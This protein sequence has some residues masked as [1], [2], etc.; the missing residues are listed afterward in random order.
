ME[1]GGE[2]EG[3]E[4]SEVEWREETFGGAGGV[5]ENDGGEQRRRE[6]PSVIGRHAIV[7]VSEQN[8]TVDKSTDPLYSYGPNLIQTPTRF[9]LLNPTTGLS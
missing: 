7:A 2:G 5:V 9:C 8:N 6:S 4:A 1:P 3:R